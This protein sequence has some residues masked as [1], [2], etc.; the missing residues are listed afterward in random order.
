MNFTY[1]V[2]PITEAQCGFAQGDSKFNRT[3]HAHNWSTSPSTNLRPDIS[4][5][6]GSRHATR[7]PPC[8]QS[9]G[10]VPTAPGVMPG[11]VATIW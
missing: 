8:R 4:E 2:F 5:G 6:A 3:S 7:L 1:H 9:Y 11:W 10:W